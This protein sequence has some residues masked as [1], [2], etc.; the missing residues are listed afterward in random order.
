MKAKQLFYAAFAATALA[1]AFTACKKDNDESD[2]TPESSMTLGSI[3][4]ASVNVDDFQTFAAR[5]DMYTKFYQWNRVTAWAATGDS[6]EGWNVTPD[7]SSTWTVNPCP[8]G[9]RLPTLAEYVA[10]DSA[11]GEYRGR[12]GVWAAATTRGN[13]VAGRFY[14][15]NCATCLLPD[16]MSG[17]VFF[18]ASGFR[19]SPDGTLG[20]LG[21][22]GFAWSCSSSP[23]IAN[24]YGLYFSSLNS[25]TFPDTKLRGFSVRC[26]RD[27]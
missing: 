20:N 25:S 14:G 23:A 21:D 16:N 2:S 10:L 6:V 27:I 9:W 19:R 8:E 1:V 7:T 22:N 26:V 13:A 11:G 4:W 3:A 15:E 12:G 24:A 5:P 17:C 18:P